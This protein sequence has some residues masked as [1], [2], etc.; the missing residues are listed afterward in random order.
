MIRSTENEHLWVGLTDRGTENVWRFVTD[1]TLYEQNEGNHLFPWATGQP[2][3]RLGEE[4]CA[5]VRLT[6]H[7]LFDRICSKAFRGLCEIK[8]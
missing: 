7:D 2:N 3:N 5:C 1:N 6:T 8:F 4:N